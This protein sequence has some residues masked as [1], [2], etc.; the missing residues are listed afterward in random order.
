MSEITIQ[1]CP[2]CDR[3]LDGI[4]T[5]VIDGDTICYV[6][7]ECHDHEARIASLEAANA[8]LLAAKA[9]AA[10]L[11]YQTRHNSD[12]ILAADGEAWD[13]YVVVATTA[14]NA[15]LAKATKGGE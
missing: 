3:P 6:C 14:A 11:R 4:G 7:A 8:V 1:L 5:R 15:D 12:V 13:D 10:S 9:L 2:E